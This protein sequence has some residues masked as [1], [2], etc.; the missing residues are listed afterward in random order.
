VVSGGVAVP[1]L[2]GATVTLPSG[3]A[4]WVLPSVSRVPHPTGVQVPCAACVRAGVVRPR[5]GMPG[6]FPGDPTPLCRSCWRSEQQRRARAAARRLE[7]QGWEEVGAAAAAAMCPVCGPG[8]AGLSVVEPEDLLPASALRVAL[9]RR[10]RG[11]L[12]PVRG[13]CWWCGDRAWLATLRWQFEQDQAAAAE[14]EAERVDAEFERI[15]AVAEAQGTVADLAGVVERLRTILTG[16]TARRRNGWGRAVELTADAYARLDA[17]RTSPRGRPSV[18]PRLV[19]AVLAADSDFM[20]GRRSLPGRERTAW[21]IGHSDRAVHDAWK[22][23]AGEGGVGWAVRTRIGGRNS[24]ERRIE[25]GRPNDRA[26][27][28]VQPLSHSPIDPAVR[29]RYVPEALGVLGDLLQ[30]AQ[31]LLDA[32]QAELDGLLAP[33]GC[34]PDWG[35]HARRAQDRQAT[36]RVLA[37]TATPEAAARIGRRVTRNYCRSHPV[38]KGEYQS[39]CSYWGWEYSRPTSI[40]SAQ[41]A[42]TPAEG[43]RQEQ[44]GAS[45]SP[46]K[47]SS[48]NSGKFRLSSQ[49]PCSPPVQRPRTAYAEQGTSHPP[50]TRK[51][52]SWADWAYDLARDLIQELPWLREQMLPREQLL[53]RVASTLGARLGPDWTAAAVLAWLGKALARPLLDNPD[54]PLAYL[55][56]ALDRALTVEDLVPPYPARAHTEHRQRLAAERHAAARAEHARLRAEFDARDAAAATASGAGRA[57]ARAVLAG[58]QARRAAAAPAEAEPWPETAQPGAGIPAPRRPS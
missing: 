40:H 35:D 57:A 31:A 48:G 26:E 19:A 9:G 50:K 16:Y 30:H 44:G 1:D 6:R 49:R 52:P 54:K 46:K 14:A 10:Q 58:I 28:D 3:Q 41:G 51:R 47:S 24:L 11:E 22:L 39:S 43:R 45:R 15:A 7:A 2:V 32:A 42:V 13:G 20:S 55:A 23:L 56:A 25:T 18:V 53:H 12:Q 36:R 33:S 8:Q 34:A 21:L 17:A 29:A 37:A 4:R 38:S 5:L 27:F